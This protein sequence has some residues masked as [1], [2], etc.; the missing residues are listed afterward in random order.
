MYPILVDWGPVVLPAWHTMYVVGAI[1]AMAIFLWASQRL[2]P[3]VLTSKLTTLY[4]ICYVFAYLGARLLS[5]FIEESE[6]I[7][8]TETLAALL[9]FGPMTFYGG[10]IAAYLVGTIYAIA[11]KLPFATLNDAGLPAGLV[12]LAL[13]RIGCFLNGDDYGKAVPLHPGDTPPWWAVTFPNL[14]DGIARYPVQIFESM[15]VACLAVALIVWTPRLRHE[16]RA[17]AVGYIAIIGYAL[18]RFLLEF[19]RDDFRG[20]PFGNWMSTSQ[21]ISLVIL[22]VAGLSIPYWI[23]KPPAAPSEGY[24]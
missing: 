13:G 19:L 10:A 15:A 22:V 9:R 18:L 23:R 1:A 5:I 17:G 6:V 2:M 3:E 12:A 14:Q 21:F 11:Q 24:S 16:F 7:G 8:I 4:A 20:F